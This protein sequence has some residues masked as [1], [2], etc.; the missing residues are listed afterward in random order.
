MKKFSFIIPI[1]FFAACE[2]NKVQFAID[3]VWSID[4]IYYKHYNIMSCISNNI[5]NIHFNRNT[6][7]PI[8]SGCENLIINGRVGTGVLT[9]EKSEDKDDTIPYRLA[10]KTKNQIFSGVHKIVFYKD[11]VNHLLKNGNIL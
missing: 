6:T 11:A 4:S 1:L 8:A 10:I 7:L 3:G 9:I 2:Q 5:L